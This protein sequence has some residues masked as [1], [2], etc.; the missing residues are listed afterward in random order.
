MPGQSFFAL[1]FFGLLA[2]FNSIRHP[3]VHDDVV[4]ILKNPHITR[5]ELWFEAF[6]VPAVSGGINTYYRP[7]LEILYRLEYHFFGPHPL[8]FHLFNCLVHVINGLL[9][10]SL[11]QKL[12]L[13]KTTAWV[14]A[15]LF[16][17]HPVQTEAV[18]CISGISN[19]WM[20]FGVLL[21]LNAYLNKWYAASLFCFVMAFLSKEQAVM[22]VPLVMVIDCNRGVKN[23]RSWV[24][25]GFVLCVLLGLRQSVTGVSLLKNIM[26]SPGEFYLRLAAIPRVIGTDLRLIFCPYDLHYYR[27]T[28]ILQPNFVSWILALISLLGIFYVLRRWPQRRSTLFLGLGWFLA[29][30]SPVLNI[31]PLV[32]EYSFILTPEHFL[33]LPIIG[34]WIVVVIAADSFIKHFKKP[35][36][37]G[38]VSLCLL[39][40]WHQNTFWGSEISLFERMLRYE[41]NFGR[42]HLLLAKAYYFNGRP[43]RADGHFEK[44]FTILSGYEKKVT[45]IM[46]EKYYLGIMKEILFDWAQN[47][48]LMGRW[49]RGLGKYKRAAIIDG[50]DAS[51]YNNMAFVYLHM[52]DKKDA[53]LSLEQALRVDPSFAQARINLQQ[54]GHP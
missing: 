48:C 29:A 41:P 16:L 53:Y 33:Y 10:F 52:G 8:G 43:E 40:T 31:A 24:S 3:F 28:D 51:L 17:I 5:L 14:I 44:S 42:G 38:I 35:L 11:L 9:I 23:Y 37:G 20:A 12:S 22:F 21:A 4:F 25:W 26:A 13:P 27:S 15:L 46:A 19:L 54:L 18:S 30:L 1:I 47:D 39:L 32:N 34:V 7:V 2:F 45:N 6:K 36:L 50:K 49:E